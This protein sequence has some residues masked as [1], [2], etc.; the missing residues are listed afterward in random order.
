M[1]AASKTI[2]VVNAKLTTTSWTT[3]LDF[4]LCLSAQQMSA[5]ARIQ[6][7]SYTHAQLAPTELQLLCVMAKIVHQANVVVQTIHV[8]RLIVQTPT[9]PFP[10]TLVVEPHAQGKNVVRRPQLPPLPC[11]IIVMISMTA[12]KTLKRTSA[13]MLVTIKQRVPMTSAVT[14]WCRQQPQP[15]T[16]HHLYRP[17]R[18]LLPV[19]HSG[20]QLVRGMRVVQVARV[21]SAGTDQ[22]EEYAIRDGA[23]SAESMMV[24]VLIG[25]PVT[26]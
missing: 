1:S 16:Q 2:P 6:P 23:A 14:R 13:E 15:L 9:S 21:Y 5:V 25:M 18:H 7:A 12:W 10:L 19:V 17:L 3:L 26:M 20:V 11:F 4:V 24:L 22:S 8:G